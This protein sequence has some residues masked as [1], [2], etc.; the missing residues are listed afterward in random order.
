MTRCSLALRNVVLT[1]RDLARFAI[2]TFPR[3]TQPY[4]IV[5]SLFNRPDLPSIRLHASASLATVIRMAT[6]GIGVAV[7][8]TAIVERELA[9][10]QLNLLATDLQ[11]PTL[12]F[13]ASWLASPD[14]LAAELVADLAVKLAQGETDAEAHAA[15]QTISAATADRPVSRVLR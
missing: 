11:V 15:T 14:T 10:G 7:I 1:A 12:T 8:P 9:E 2:I 4:E 6:D 3:K 5:R 13:A